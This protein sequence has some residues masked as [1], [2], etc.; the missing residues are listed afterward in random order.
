MT[1]DLGS[2]G[3]FREGFFSNG[4]A[5]GWHR[6]AG[7]AP[8][9]LSDGGGTQYMARGIAYGCRYYVAWM[10]PALHKRPDLHSNFDDAT[11]A[12]LHI[13]EHPDV[14]S[15]GVWDRRLQRWVA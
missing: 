2:K 6:P 10:V 11:D 4:M 8:Q 3:S 13:A 5:D 15:G 12:V 14:F 9:P 7:P 1:R